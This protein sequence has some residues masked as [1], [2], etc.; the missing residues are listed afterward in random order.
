MEMRYKINLHHTKF[1]SDKISL[2]VNF[3]MFSILFVSQKL[4]SLAIENSSWKLS[5]EKAT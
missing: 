3:E 2:H 1:S 4:N 5:A